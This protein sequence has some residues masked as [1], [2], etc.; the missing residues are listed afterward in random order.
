MEVIK[1]F[2]KYVLFQFFLLLQILLL[3]A[4]EVE[5]KKEKEEMKLKR[6]LDDFFPDE[7]EKSSEVVLGFKEVWKVQDD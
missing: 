6:A 2:N 1:H 7:T 3:K 4:I 5:E